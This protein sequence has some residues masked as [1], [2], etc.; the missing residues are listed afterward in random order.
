MVKTLSLLASSSLFKLL[1]RLV[2][3]NVAYLVAQFVS[4]MVLTQTVPIAEVGRFSWALALTS[5]IFVLADMRT[6]QVQM[7]SLVE[8]Y[9]YRTFMLQRFVALAFAVP[10]TVFI[11]WL[12]TPD[13]ETFYI[14]LALAF[15]KSVE[16]ILSVVIGEHLR[17]EN[18]NIVASTQIVRGI[19]YALMFCTTIVITSRASITVLVTAISMILPLI[20]AVRAI[21]DYERGLRASSRQLRDVSRESLPIGIGFFIGS[22]TVNSPR[23]LIE[24]FH[25][26]ESLAIFTAVSYVVVLANTVVE[27]ISQGTMPRLAL[28]WRNGLVVRAKR[29]TVY[30]GLCVFMFGLS[31]IGASVF[32]GEFLLSILYGTDYASGTAI[33]VALLS[34]AT[35]QY[36]SSTTRSALIAK[37]L[38]LGVFWIS[39]L[40][41]VVTMIMSIVF[42]PSGH[43]SMAGWALATGQFTQLII[44]GF[45]LLRV[46]NGVGALDSSKEAGQRKR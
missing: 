42:I 14:V 40:N 22:M 46:P 36:V 11:G 8:T 30:I 31:C 24:E 9:S 10:I 5:P 26:I 45:L 1:Q 37:G 32:A 12:A 18:G 17:A 13:R 28:Y 6:R 39:M 41:F 29:L 44:Y 21:P 3:G 33:L 43:A 35:L 25:G 20:F 16:A 7:S 38:R 15:L 2:V 4:F 19:T 23:F 27:S 34:Y